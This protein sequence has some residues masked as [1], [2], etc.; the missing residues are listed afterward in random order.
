MIEQNRNIKVLMLTLKQNQLLNFIILRIEKYGVSPSYEEMCEELELKS[1]SG[2]NRI[3]KSLEERG[4]I[5]RLENKAR[6]IAPKKHPNGQTY[7]SDVINFKD[8]FINKHSHSLIKNLNPQKDQIPLL[9][10]IAAGTPIEAISNYGEYLDVPSSFLTS[11]D[12]YALYVEGDSMIDEGIFDGDTVII[13]KKTNINNGD[14]IVALIDNE[15]ATLKKFRKKGDSIA[16]EPANKNYKTQIYGPDRIVI[17]GKMS[18]LIR[19]YN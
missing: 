4:Y 9:G 11:E 1:K 5:E 2:I 3:V 18:G 10:K 7:N 17:Q 8:K 13:D 16:L 14:I 6:A 19:S 15:E 12:C